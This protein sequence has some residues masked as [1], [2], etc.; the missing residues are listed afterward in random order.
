MHDTVMLE[1]KGRPTAVIVTR[2]FVHEAEAQR[3]ALGMTSLGSVVIDHP[4]S[5]L[6]EEEIAQRIEQA[7]PQIEGVWLTPTPPPNLGGGMGG[8]T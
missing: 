4:L 8:V 5:S 6:K 7:L 2:E 1:A 3:D